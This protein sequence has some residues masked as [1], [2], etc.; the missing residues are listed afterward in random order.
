[1]GEDQF[2]IEYDNSNRLDFA[3]GFGLIGD[4][5]EAKLYNLLKTYDSNY[6]LYSVAEENFDKAFLEVVREESYNLQLIINAS[7][8]LNICLRMVNT[9]DEI[10]T[11]IMVYSHLYFNNTTDKVLT[12]NDNK[13]KNYYDINIVH[14][15]VSYPDRGTRKNRKTR[16]IRNDITHDGESLII[17]NP[18]KEGSGIYSFVTLD[19]LKIR[20]IE[21][22]IKIINEISEDI[23]VLKQD[24]KDLEA[25]ILKDKHFV[26]RP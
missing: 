3:F 8:Y 13:Y 4:D 14:D 2:H 10:M 6:Y 17:N 12:K 18:V 21:L 16:S 20:N 9:L 19:G 26:K 7:F 22:Y 11:K 24:R 25:I 5:V 23:R 15:S 1:V